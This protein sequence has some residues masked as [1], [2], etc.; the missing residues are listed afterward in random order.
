MSENIV[1]L[2]AES[3]PDFISKETVI[4]DF[5][6]SWCAPCRLLSENLEKETNLKIGKLNVDEFPEITK[7][8]GVKAL[9]TLLFFK[10]GEEKVKLIGMQSL[11]VI[12]KTYTDLK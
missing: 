4:V 11:P 1:E 7:K 3:F 9:P 5:Y 8:Y 6:A 2:N 12:R 10:E